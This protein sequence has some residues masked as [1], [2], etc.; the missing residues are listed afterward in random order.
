MK[1]G[2][3]MGV[4]KLSELLSVLVSETVAVSICGK[5]IVSFAPKQSFSSSV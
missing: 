4:E 2:A 1:K 3:E 5:Y